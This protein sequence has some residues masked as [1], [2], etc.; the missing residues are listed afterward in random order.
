VDYDMQPRA[1]LDDDV[2]V[3]EGMGVGVIRRYHVESRGRLLMVVSYFNNLGGRTEQIRVFQLQVMPPDA[4]AGG[5]RPRAAWENLGNQ[6]DM[7]CIAVH[8]SGRGF[9]TAA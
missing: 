2:D 5:Q 9:Y 6:L 4:A 3:Y 7:K 1:D 8:S